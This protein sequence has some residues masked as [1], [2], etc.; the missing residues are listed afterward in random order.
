MTGLGPL[1]GS[2]RFWSQEIPAPVW[3]DLG[4]APRFRLADP[5]CNELDQPCHGEASICLS[6]FI[7]RVVLMQLRS[8]VRLN[9]KPVRCVVLLF[10]IHLSGN[11]A[12][13]NDNLGY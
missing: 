1:T 2:I 13:S 7:N 12:K 8:Q 11:V 3:P 4:S 6:L 10:G 9:R 5:R